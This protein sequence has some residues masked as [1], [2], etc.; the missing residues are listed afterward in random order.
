MK[1]DTI[2][3][4]GEWAALPAEARRLEAAGYD[5]AWTVETGHDPFLPLGVAAAATTPI[6]LGTSILSVP[7]ASPVPSQM[8]RASAVRRSPD[9]KS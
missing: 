8:R 2:L 9:Q 1:V 6:R 4:T 7:S 3:P 5:A